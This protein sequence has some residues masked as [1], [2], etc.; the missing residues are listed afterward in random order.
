VQTVTQEY[1]EELQ[2]Y[3]YEV[4]VHKKHTMFC[5]LLDDP[6]TAVFLLLKR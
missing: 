1:T 4:C 3:Q 2:K 5:G 6:L